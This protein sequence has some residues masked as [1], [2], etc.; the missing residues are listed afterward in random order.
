MQQS[1]SDRTPLFGEIGKATGISL[2]FTLAAVLVFAFIIKIFSLNT[3]VIK[4]VNQ[5]LKV[6]SIFTGCYFSLSGRKGWLKG[7]ITG[8]FVILLTYFIFAIISGSIEFNWSVIVEII[9]GSI[10][11]AISGIITVNLKK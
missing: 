5:F 4:P 2:I 9:F 3:E 10:I 6:I 8:L 11:G 1:D 7:L